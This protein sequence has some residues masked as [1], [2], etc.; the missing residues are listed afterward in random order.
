MLANTATL[1]ETDS[2]RTSTVT[3]E[4]VN[5]LCTDGV[6]RS[7]CTWKRYLAYDYDVDGVTGIVY[8]Y[9][10]TNSL[11]NYCF[12]Q[13]AI[14]SAAPGIDFGSSTT[15]NAYI[16]SFVFNQKLIDYDTL[17]D[18][19]TFT[20]FGTQATLE[21]A[22]CDQYWATSATIDA[23]IGFEF[24]YHDGRNTE[25]NGDSK[26][27]GGANVGTTFSYLPL[28]TLSLNEMLTGISLNGVFFFTPT[29]NYGV[30]AL[31]PV[32]YGIVTGASG[33]KLD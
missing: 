27:N 21:S 1:T 23:N 10:A 16:W 12:Y 20:S 9:F 14:V 30:D 17:S 2:G 32:N 25:A 31:F 4:G 26:I 11:P 13:D 7:T 29:Y 5:T 15:Y 22:Q 6:M 33:A 3:C 28:K 18:S 19:R 24:F 8:S